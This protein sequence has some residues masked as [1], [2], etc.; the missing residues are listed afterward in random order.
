MDNGVEYVEQ[1][2][3]RLQSEAND[4]R[5]EVKR[6]NKLAFEAMSLAVD[7]GKPTKE[8]VVLVAQ[9]ANESGAESL[10]ELSVVV[11]RAMRACSSRWALNS[12]SRPPPK[13]KV[14]GEVEDWDPSVVLLSSSSIK[15]CSP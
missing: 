6:L 11:G 13:P 10:S 3:D 15:A 5:K 1:R 14:G 4:L 12:C 7:G 2:A 9:R 8:L